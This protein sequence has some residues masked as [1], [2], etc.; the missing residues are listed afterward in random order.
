MKKI[1]T[2]LALVA[3]LF[4]V[5]AQTTKTMTYGGTTRQYLEYVPSSYN[6]G[7]APVLF[8]LHGLGDD[9]NNMFTGTG[10]KQ[11][12]D[13]HGWIVITPQALEASVSLMGQN[14]SLG[15][16][17]NSGVSANLSFLGNIIVND[18]VDDSGF[19]MAILDDLIST[20]NVDQANVFSMGFSMGGFMSNRLAIEHGDRI[21]AIAAVSGTIGNEVKTL[22]PVANVNTLHFHGTSDSTVG[23][24][25]ADFNVMGMSA[26]VGLGAEATVDYWRNYNQCNATPTVTNF[27]NS[28]NDGLTFEKYAYDNGNNGSKT[29]FIKVIGGDHTWYYTPNNDI[30]YTTEIYNFFASCLV[31]GNDIDDNDN[32]VLIFPNPAN[33]I[34][35][36]Q[37]EGI[38]QV[39][40]FN[41]MGQQVLTSNL[42]RIDISQLPE[43]L[44]VANIIFQNGNSTNQ[45][46][47]IN[48]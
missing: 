11:V 26:S 35:S 40:L 14:I 4:S 15:T 27:P 19:I 8:V 45:K 23:Y 10:F 33:N 12:A 25:N 6:G 34:L 17:W 7:P 41:A 21:N 39:Q 48:R 36:I 9:M 43:G 29:H 22:T 18:G 37:A 46:V 28:A 32:N 13:Q 3:F 44:Y 16:A 1:Y 30:D 20:Y 42:S 31:G 47:V 2:L 5:Q 38:S 24:D